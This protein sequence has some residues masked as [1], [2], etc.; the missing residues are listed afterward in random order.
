MVPAAGFGLTLLP[1]RGFARRLSARAMVDNVGAAWGLTRAVARAAALVRRLRPSVVVAVGGYAGV[2]CGLAA[3]AARIPLVVRRAERG[4]GRRQPPPGPVRPGQRRLLPRHRPAPGASSP[5]TR[6]GPRS[7]PST[8]PT[9]DGPRPG[10]P[11]A[12]PTGRRVVAVTGGSLGRPAHQ[13]GRARA[14]SSGGPDR[15]DL[16][17]RHAVGA[18]DW[19]LVAGRA[20]GAPPDGRASST[21]RCATRTAWTCCWPRPTSLVCRAG[22][23]TVAEVAAVGR[24]GG[25]GPPARRPRRPPDGQRPGPGRRRRGGARAR[26]RARRRPAGGRG[27]GAC[28]PTPTGWRRW[29]R[30]RPPAGAATPPTGWPPSSRPTPARR[31]ARPSSTSGRRPRRVDLRQPRRIHVVGVGG[32][33]MSAI[34]EVLAGMGHQVSGSDLRPSAVLDRLAGLGVRVH[35]GHD[36]ANLGPASGRR[37]RHLH[38]RARRQPRGGRGPGAAAS[39]CCAAADVLAAICGQRRTIAVSG[40][41]GKTTTSSLLALGLVGAGLRPSFVVGGEI[42]GLGSGARWDDG[43]WMVVEAD[44]S[45]GTFLELPCDIAV[46]TSVEPDHLE[47][48]GQLR[49]AGGRLRPLPRPT[50]PGTAWCAPTTRA[51]PPSAAAT[52]PSPTGPRRPPTCG[53]S[54]SS[55]GGR[56]CASACSTTGG[57]WARS[58]CPLPGLHNARN[59]AGAVGRG[60]AG[61][62]RFAAGGGG[63]GRA[64]PAS[65]AGSRSGASAGASPSSTTTPTSRAR[66]RRRWPRPATASWERVVCVFQPHRYSR[67]AALWR[68][69]GAVLRRRR[70]ARW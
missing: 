10:P 47:H 38:R 68:D 25:A 20:A 27:R 21:S 58:R 55:A 8:G 15:G 23:N 1:G 63:G 12:C 31:G 59:A 48:Y 53:W 5:A 69:F 3:A 22:G 56:R 17:V 28:W 30:R 24:A 2:P 4:A 33:G 54:R 62:R 41:H 36:A 66:W 51:R 50:P 7:S 40:T 29:A 67:T 19:D 14:R 60:P 46:V 45:D 57:R 43:E 18:R 37:G 9:P 34:A 42:I 61:G 26:R 64:R 13:P 39:R 16:A 65:A 11:S 32:A 6:C 52:A 44:E 35:V 70:P 49:R